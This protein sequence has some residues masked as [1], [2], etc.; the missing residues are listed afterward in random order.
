[1]QTK[2]IIKV[3]TTFS[4]EDVLLTRG[5]VFT[6]N[7]DSPSQTLVVLLEGDDIDF[8]GNCCCSCWDDCFVNAFVWPVQRLQCISYKCLP[9]S[10]VV[11]NIGNSFVTVA[12]VVVL[13]ISV[14]WHVVTV[15]AVW[16]SEDK[17]LSEEEIP[18]QLVGIDPYTTSEWFVFI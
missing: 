11:S 1:M 18:V 7:V 12:I 5:S 9:C 8:F 6:D 14:D 13:V 2:Q 4:P 17:E 15:V 10:L 3:K 16:R